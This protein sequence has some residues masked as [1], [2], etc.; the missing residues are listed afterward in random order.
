LPE[1][2]YRAAAIG[3]GVTHQTFVVQEGAIG[4]Q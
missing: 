1:R 3:T 4:D 2:L